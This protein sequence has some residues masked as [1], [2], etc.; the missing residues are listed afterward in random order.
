LD[1]LLNNVFNLIQAHFSANASEPSSGLFQELRHT[2]VCLKIQV[3]LDYI[4]YPT[5]YCV[6]I[7][8][9]VVGRAC[10]LDGGGE[11]HVQ[12]FGGET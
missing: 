7:F 6:L 12:G 4:I 11:R 8:Q 10:S 3:V 2:T 5:L 1:C 9:Y